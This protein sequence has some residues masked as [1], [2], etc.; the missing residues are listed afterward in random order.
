MRHGGRKT[1]NPTHGDRFRHRSR[2]PPTAPAA[3]AAPRSRTRGVAL[4]AR[5]GIAP[6]LDQKAG[7]IVLHAAG[8]PQDRAVPG[9]GAEEAVDLAGVEGEADKAL[10]GVAPGQSLRVIEAAV[11]QVG[12]LRE[13]P[14]RGRHGLDRVHRLGEQLPDPAGDHQR[15]QARPR[16]A[17]ARGRCHAAGA[18]PVR[19]DRD[20]GDQDRESAEPDPEEVRRRGS[21]R[22]TGRRRRP[23]TPPGPA[24]GGGWRP[25]RRR[26]A[27][28]TPAAPRRSRRDRGTTAA[29]APG[30]RAAGS[31]PR[32]RPGASG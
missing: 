22:E 15:H 8:M 12:V 17:L 1:T 27:A 6:G 16:A 23:R 29:R 30:A 19:G 9:E 10:V 21:G 5:D 2:L 11:D 32:A 28:E 20:G 31:T 4:S 26:R 18:K 24:P 3:A 14:G 13:E 25:G 7:H